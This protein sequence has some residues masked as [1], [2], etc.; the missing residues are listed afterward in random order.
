VA[1]V[2]FLEADSAYTSLINGRG[3]PVDLDVIAL[4]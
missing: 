1:A 2:D 4:T 3:K